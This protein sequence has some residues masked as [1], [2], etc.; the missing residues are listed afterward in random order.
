MFKLP[1]EVEKIIST[2]ENAGYTAWCVGGSV[3]D[4]LMGKTPDDFDIASSAPCEKIEDLFEKTVPTGIKHGTVTVIKSGVPY[5]VTRYRIDGEYRDNRHPNE[6]EFTDD[7]RA[8]LSRRD[9]TVNAIG[10]NPK[11]GIFDP[12]NGI[13][14]INNKI[15]RAVGNPEKR[16]SEDALR[17][18]RAFRFAA[19]LEFSIEPNTLKFACKQSALLKNIASERIAAELLKA[20]S[21]QKPSVLTKL[22]FSGGLLHIGINSNSDILLLDSVPNIPLLRLAVLCKL[23]NAD[24]SNVAKNLRLS[25]KQQLETEGYYKI[26]TFKTVNVADIKPF[27]K[28]LGYNNLPLTIDAFGIINNVDVTEIKGKM[29]NSVIRNDPYC[30]EMLNISGNDLLDMGFSGTDI[31]KVQQI[32]LKEVLCDYRKNDPKSLKK[33]ARNLL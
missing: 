7:F 10:Y 27:A 33:M 11:F 26:L 9:F 16:F 21:A 17:I 6:V 20:L 29:L 2:I 1:K 19:T 32:L 18:L 24:A 13:D 12:F 23:A 8:D 22:I 30:V 14:D 25:R 15:I 3:R 5:E 31:G 28:V 4:M